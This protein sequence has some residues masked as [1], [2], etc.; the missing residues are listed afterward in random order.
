MEKKML[1]QPLFKTVQCD[2]FLTISL[3]I[4][5]YASSFTGKLSLWI[6]LFVQLKSFFLLKNRL[7]M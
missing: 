6:F 7:E 4:R 1:F 3:E 2:N 5:W